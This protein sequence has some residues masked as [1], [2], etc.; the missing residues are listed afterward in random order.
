MAICQISADA[1]IGQRG[2]Y[3]FWKLPLKFVFPTLVAMV[4]GMVVVVV[5]NIVVELIVVVS[6]EAVG[7]VVVFNEGI[8]VIVADRNL[9]LMMM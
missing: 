8:V 1:S 9:R 6:V 5:V 4:V 3:K 7:K 2:G